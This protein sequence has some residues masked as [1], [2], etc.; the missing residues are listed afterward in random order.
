MKGLTTAPL[1]ADDAV[2]VARMWHDCELHDD[3]KALVTEEDFVTVL[4][5]P[6]LEFQRDTV[7]VRDGDAIVAAGLLFG[8]RFVFANVAPSHRGRGVGTWLLRWSEDAGRAAGRNRSCQKLSESQHA[9]IAL[10]EAAG[11]ERTWEDWIFDIELERA[12]DPPALPPGYAFRPFVQDRDGRDVHGVIEGAFAEWPDP[13]PEAFDDWAAEVFGRPS[14]LPEHF[15]IVVRGDETAGA[16]LLIEEDEEL[17]VAQLAVARAHRGR[18]LG[19][20]LLV[21]AFGSAWRSGRRHVGLATDGR[22]GAR[23]LYEH[24]GMHVTRTAWEYAKLL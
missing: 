23:G 21:H 8:E 24:V 13:E 19:R 2:R 22:T 14:F 18:G 15:G 11:Y 7:A 4:Q 12:P 1:A 10:L 16:A 9:A 3:G 17:W 6:S 20:A 5:R